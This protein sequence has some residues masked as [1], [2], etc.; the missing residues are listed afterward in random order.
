M[1]SPLK[2][3][4]RVVSCFNQANGFAVGSVEGRVA[5]QYADDKD[6]SNNFSFKCHR[7][8]QT[9]SQKDQSLV[10]AVN[11]ISFHPVHGTFSTCGSDGTVHFWD[12]DARTRL[13]S[14]CGRSQYTPVC[15]FSL[16][17]AAFEN[18]N[19]PIAATA[20]N[21]TGNIF[22]Y[23]VSYDWHKVWFH[24]LFYADA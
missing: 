6:A 3:Q 18:A 15:S 2:W 23:A 17:A 11:D 21:R 9:P 12:K 10:Y 24:R 4:T 1:P 19:G 14:T 5:I 7:R 13:K 8:D 20:F 22:A 16:R